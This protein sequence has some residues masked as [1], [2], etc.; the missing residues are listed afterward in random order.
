MLLGAYN[1]NETCQIDRGFAWLVDKGEILGKRSS[2][3]ECRQLGRARLAIV[4]LPSV[5]IRSVRLKVQ[6]YALENR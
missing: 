3:V 6:V 2:I 4:I 1:A 5:Q